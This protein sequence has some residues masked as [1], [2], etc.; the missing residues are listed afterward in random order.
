MAPA[1]RVHAGP[2]GEDYRPVGLL[3]SQR[4][5]SQ[6]RASHS[7]GRCSTRGLRGPV[8]RVGWIE[9]HAL[10]IMERVVPAP[11]WQLL[12]CLEIPFG[13][14]SQQTVPSSGASVPSNIPE[15]AARP[16]LEAIP[17]AQ[18]PAELRS[19]APSEL[20]RRLAGLGLGA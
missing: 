19:K 1:D 12:L 9:G 16:I 4:S 2:L 5:G 11:L 6:L 18:R 8:S 3:S 14:F 13:A 17:P 15:P 10:R 7:Q 20:A